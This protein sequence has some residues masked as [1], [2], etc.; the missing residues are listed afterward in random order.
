MVTPGQR[1][2]AVTP[3]MATAGI[4]E[5]RACRY[6]GFARSSRRYRARRASHDAIRARVHTLAVLRPR[7]GY[8][9]LS[10]S[11]RREGVR[12]NR[13]LVQR[14]Y[15]EE[16]LTVRRRARNRVAVPRAP[17]LEA[18]TPNQHWS[19][20]VVSDALGDGRRFRALTIVD[21]YTRECPAIEV[22]HSL[23][24]RASWR[25]WSDSRGLAGYPT[26]SHATTVPSFAVKPSINGRQR[27][28]YI[29]TSLI[30]GNPC[31]MRTPKA[32]T[33]ACAMN[34]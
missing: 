19:M 21:D 18:T 28:A 30:L 17:R 7:W 12:V 14:R 10:R 6:T 2:T 32:S 33:V 31:R 16:G 24:A 15:R 23:P 13:T 25:C 1:R 9:R 22:D 27:V 5:R 4:S 34:A 29:C 8:R 11:L 3:A 20:D 26:P